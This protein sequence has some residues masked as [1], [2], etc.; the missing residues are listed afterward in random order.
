VETFHFLGQ[1]YSL[2]NALYV[3]EFCASSLGPKEFACEDSGNSWNS[4]VQKYQCC[5]NPD[6]LN[7]D[8]DPAFQV[9]RIQGFDKQ[10][11]EK[12]G[13]KFFKIFF[14]QKLQFTYP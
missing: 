3:S 10:K 6:S 7:P 4:V 9:N 14:E 5:E 13:L 11:L 2:N 1:F 8:P 12:Y